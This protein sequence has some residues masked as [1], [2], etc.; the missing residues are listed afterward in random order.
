MLQG[1]GRYQI[2]APIGHGATADVYRAYDPTLD[3][4][5]AIKVLKL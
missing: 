1:I 3:R 5:L 4:V 2:Q